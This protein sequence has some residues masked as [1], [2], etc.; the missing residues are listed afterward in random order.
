MLRPARLFLFLFLFLLVAS[1]PA[2]SAFE[3]RI[4][5]TL[6]TGRETEQLI[7]YAVKGALIRLD[8]RTEEAGGSAL[9][10]D[11]T[12]HTMVI[13]MPAQKLYVRL[14]LRGPAPATGADSAPPPPLAATE[15]APG[16]AEKFLGLPCTRHVF[17]NDDGSTL[18]SWVTT[19]L[20]G[21][22]PLGASPLAALLGGGAP[23]SALER[24]GAAFPLKVVVRDA[25]GRE[26]FRFEALQVEPARLPD[27]LFAVPTDF[28]PLTLPPAKSAEG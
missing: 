4:Q 16:S 24:A 6:K 2:V 5:F 23:L 12:A 21:L 26:T 3:G 8:P 14:P 27:D 15:A 28:Q 10:I 20:G 19:A 9:L 7:D 25:R 11:T 13:L 22:A 1:A 17:A 18:E